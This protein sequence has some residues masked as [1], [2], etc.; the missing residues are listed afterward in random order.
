MSGGRRCSLLVA[1]DDAAL[2]LL[3]KRQLT[4]LNCDV[5]FAENGEQA[6]IMAKNKS[7]DL[8]FMDVMMPGTDGLSATEQ[9][10][11]HEGSARK[12]TPIVAMTAF[13]DRERCLEAGMDDFL[14]KPVLLQNIRDVLEKWISS[15]QVVELSE[16]PARKLLESGSFERREEK[17]QSLKERIE[18]LRARHLA[19]E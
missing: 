14:F 12:R 13:V 15:S 9:I 5:D 19:D 1:E 18:R 16:A 11:K 2:R 6:I 10:R 4:L 17:L 7:Y 3:V 8:I